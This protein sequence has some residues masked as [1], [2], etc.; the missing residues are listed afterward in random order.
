VTVTAAPGVRR[1]ALTWTAPIAGTTAVTDYIVQ[2]RRSTSA[3]WVTL[4][5]GVRTTRS[6]TV[7]G[8]ATGATYVFRVAAKNSVGT[9]PWSAA[10][11]AKVK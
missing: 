10:V 4:N 7:T 6:A 1:V 3:T 9:G 2:Y 11:T 5:D 8:L